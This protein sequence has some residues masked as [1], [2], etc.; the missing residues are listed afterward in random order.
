MS[1][2]PTTLPQ[3][4]CSHRCLVRT[5]VARLVVLFAVTYVLLLSF[6][7]SV[8]GQFPSDGQAKSREEFDAYLLV[9]SKSAP[10]EVI[11]AAEDFEE[12]W[13]H[14]EL[15]GQ[16]FELRLSAYRSLGD[17]VQAILAGEKALRV[18]PDN[19]AILSNLAYIIANS[20][21]DPQRLAQAEGYARKELR[22][23]KTILIP[24]KISPEEWY[25]IRSRLDSTA[26]AAL[27]LVAYK[28]GDIPG[29]IREFETAVKLA[30]A[31]DPAQCYRLGMLYR[32][33]G[34]QSKAIEMLQRTAASN[35]PTLRQLA[36]RELRS[37]RP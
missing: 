10:K 37:L 6:A 20:T 17:S 3:N 9:L 34:N 24:K 31:P 27:G 2:R 8:E 26:H 15:L 32:T 35:D 5:R 7:T 28:R 36:E 4:R 13:P 16:V 22:L 33:S 21:T 19:L 14:S 30:P 23:S 1:K 12:R 29:A 25:E 11:S 18:V